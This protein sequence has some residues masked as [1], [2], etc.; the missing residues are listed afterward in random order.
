[1][2]Y[3]AKEGEIRGCT[4]DMFNSNKEEEVETQDPECPFEGMR[5]SECA[6]HP[7]YCGLK[8]D[9]NMKKV[10]VSPL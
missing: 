10:G 8:R 1:M 2:Y 6:D 7:S 3:E 4:P 9:P 5:Y